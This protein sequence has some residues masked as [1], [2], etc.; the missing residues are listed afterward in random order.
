MLS[1][2][3]IFF[4]SNG[5]TCPTFLQC[6]DLATKYNREIYRNH[7]NSNCPMK[8]GWGGGIVMQTMLKCRDNILMPPTRQGGGGW[9]VFLVLIFFAVKDAPCDTAAQGPNAADATS[10]RIG[11]DLFVISIL[12]GRV[13]IHIESTVQG[14][15]AIF[16]PFFL[17]VHVVRVAS[18]YIN[19]QF[20][21]KLSNRSEKVQLAPFLQI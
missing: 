8:R 11:P 19:K 17:I 15:L 16:K 1:L 12:L 21:K 6:R 4:F 3:E 10:C 14:K 5:S 13:H 20:S 18:P 9:L 7:T 2:R